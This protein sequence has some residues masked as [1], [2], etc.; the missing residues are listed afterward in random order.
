MSDESQGLS[1]TH[2]RRV[3]LRWIGRFGLGA[4]LISSYGS[5]AAFMGRFLYPAR[6][7]TRRW[8]FVTDVVSM[9]S[10]DALTYQLP[11]GNPVTVARHGTAGGVEDFRALSSTCPHLGCQVF[12]EAH[13]DRFFCPCHNGVFSPEGIGVG[14]PPGDAG[15]SL[16]EFPLKVEGGLLFIEVPV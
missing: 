9:A 15:Q 8:M 3:F 7:A 1:R 4:G 6:P 14:G 12:W 10:G 13:N 2:P 5:L 16:P 11:D